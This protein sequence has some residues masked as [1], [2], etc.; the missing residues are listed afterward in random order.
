M[1]RTLEEDTEPG[2]NLN[3][4][5]ANSECVYLQLCTDTHMYTETEPNQAYSL[6]SQMQ[7]QDPCTSIEL[8]LCAT[9]ILRRA[10]NAPWY[11]DQWDQGQKSYCTGPRAHQIT[12]KLVPP[13]SWLCQILP[14]DMENAIGLIR[15]V[16][17]WGV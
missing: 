1:N 9:G 13:F 7:E 16:H 4:K 11:G 14:S 12:E 3:V 15:S 8:L 2:T 17:R 10:A 6:R 5:V